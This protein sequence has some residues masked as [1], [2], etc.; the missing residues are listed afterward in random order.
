MSPSGESC[1]VVTHLRDDASG[2][3]SDTGGRIGPK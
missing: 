3:L 1:M 2:P